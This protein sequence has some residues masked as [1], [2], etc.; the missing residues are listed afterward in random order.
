VSVS[1]VQVLLTLVMSCVCRAV[2]GA[3]GYRASPALQARILASDS[4]EKV[5]GDVFRARG[6][7]LVELPGI[8]REELLAAIPEYD[9]LVVR[10]RTKVTKEIID[11]GTNL[12]MIGRAGTGVDNIDTSYA[13]NK[14]ILVVNTPGGNTVSTAELAVS[15]ILALA[16]NI[17][18]ATASLKEGSF[19]LLIR[20]STQ[21]IISSYV[22]VCVFGRSSFTFC[23]EMVV[24]HSTDNVN[25][26]ICLL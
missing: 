24:I 2:C 3:R 13:T 5:C 6:H 11:A 19:L 18:Q 12:K 9:G 23:L 15:H 22:C 4:I 7:E 21:W 14:G 26:C 1:L 10:S 8:S 20:Y 16:R 17:P 25:V